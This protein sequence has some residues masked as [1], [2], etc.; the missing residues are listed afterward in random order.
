MKRLLFFI[1]I[2]GFSGCETER[3]TFNGPYHVRFTNSTQTE[4]E[5]NS[6][7]IK[8]EVHNAGPELTED[9]IVNYTISGNAR[10]D[11][12][13]SIVGTKGRTTIKKGEYILRRSFK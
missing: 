6:Q 11:I 2:T 9:L 5:S 8:I 13:Y 1:L 7:I 3:I 12:D 4:K 10:P